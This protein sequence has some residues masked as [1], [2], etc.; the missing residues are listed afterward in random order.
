MPRRLLAYLVALCAAVAAMGSAVAA[1]AVFPPGLRI[2]L[3]PP[4]DLKPSTHF[5]GFEDIDRK[6]SRHHSRPAGRRL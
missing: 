3:A 2:G 1:E 5:P 6:V 4:G